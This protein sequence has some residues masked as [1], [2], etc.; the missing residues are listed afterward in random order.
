MLKEI[1]ADT[2]IDSLAQPSTIGVLYRGFLSPESP[3]LDQAVSFFHQHPDKEKFSGNVGVAFEAYTDLYVCKRNTELN[4]L[5]EFKERIGG[6][7]IQQQAGLDICASLV[8]FNALEG[9]TSHRDYSYNTHALATLVLS[10]ELLYGCAWTRHQTY[11]PQQMVLLG[12][13]DLVLLQATTPHIKERPF[14]CM[15]APSSSLISRLWI[16]DPKKCGQCSTGDIRG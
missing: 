4:F 3:L 13:R 16:R 14:F 1:H 2:Q 10:G 9:M 12:K 11:H 6:R 15:I 5:S 7:L 8:G